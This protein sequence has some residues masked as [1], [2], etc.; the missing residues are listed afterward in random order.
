M[1]TATVLQFNTAAEYKLV[2]LFSSMRLVTSSGLLFLDFFT[3]LVA[4]SRA[5]RSDL[6]NAVPAPIDSGRVLFLRQ[7]RPELAQK[8]AVGHLIVLLGLGSELEAIITGAKGDTLGLSDLKPLTPGGE[9]RPTAGQ[10]GTFT[11]YLACLNRVGPPIAR[12]LN[13]K[14]G[15]NLLYNPP[16][17]G[18]PEYPL[19]FRGPGRSNTIYLPTYL[20]TLL[21]WFFHLLFPLMF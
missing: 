18:L 6:V 4:V 9:S 20:P 14:I 1:A 8:F 15:E 17:E 11:P 12:R 7:A 21:C 16:V 3:T 10:M 2:R 5:I 13:E 19:A